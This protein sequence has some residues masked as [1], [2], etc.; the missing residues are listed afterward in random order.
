MS[1]A[2]DHKGYSQ[3]RAC[4]LVHIN[5][6]VYRY[7]ST[8]P[9]DAG[10]RKRLREL[11]SERRRFGYRRLHILLQREGVA[12]NWKKLYRLYKEERL[13]VRKRGGRKRVLGTRAPM[14]IPQDPNQRWSLDFVSDTLVDGRRFRILCIIDD[15]SRE[16]LAAVPDSSI[17]GVRV[18][19]ELDRIAEQRGYPCMVVSDNGTELTSNAILRWQEERGVEW[20]YIAPGK[21]MQNGFVESFNGRLRDECLNEH[22]FTSYRHAREII[23]HWRTDYNVNRPHT[24]LE[25]LTPHEFATRSRTDHNVNRTNL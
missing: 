9:D 15:F 10:L 6:R 19:R 8:R 2:I 7:R 3:R 12:I 1:W 20:H 4:G 18:A 16:C 11:A 14:A 24:S 21:P 25:G 17:S 13:T 23:E 22:L 5:P